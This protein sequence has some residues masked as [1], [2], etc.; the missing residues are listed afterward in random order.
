MRSDEL[1]RDRGARDNLP[2]RRL[3]QLGDFTPVDIASIEWQR[4]PSPVEMMRRRGKSTILT[5]GLDLERISEKMQRS[6]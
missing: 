3:Q 2:I 6:S 5:E 4:H 1:L